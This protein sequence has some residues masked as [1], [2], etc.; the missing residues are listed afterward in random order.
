MNIYYQSNT[1][2][3]GKSILITIAIVIGII[4][5][6]I[7][8][9]VRGSNYKYSSSTTS[10]HCNY[11]YDKVTGEYHEMDCEHDY[12]YLDDLYDDYDRYDDYDYRDYDYDYDY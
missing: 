2:K 11:A 1:K 3:S 8:G 7:F 5:L 4:A 9:A 6:I 12:D 10:N